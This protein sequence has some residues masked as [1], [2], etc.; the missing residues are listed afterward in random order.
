M[1][2]ATSQVGEDA[3]RIQKRRKYNSAASNKRYHQRQKLL[4]HYKNMFNNHPLITYLY[5]ARHLLIKHFDDNTVV[6]ILTRVGQ[7]Y[8]T[9]ERFAQYMRHQFYQ[10]QRSLYN[11][12][13]YTYSNHHALVIGGSPTPTIIHSDPSGAEDELSIPIESSKINHPDVVSSQPSVNVNDNNIDTMSLPPIIDEDQFEQGKMKEDQSDMLDIMRRSGMKSR[14][15]KR[16]AF[17]PGRERVVIAMVAIIVDLYSNA[18]NSDK[19]G[20]V[21][22]DAPFGENANTP[23]PNCNARKVMRNY[24][25]RVINLAGWMYCYGTATGA[26]TVGIPPK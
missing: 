25:G 23:T 12:L 7:Q 14:L 16:W 22:I 11:G 18:L 20:S 8:L 6:G 21:S 4:L 15:I 2:A 17:Q 19:G 10:Q 9:Q 13:P 5:K 26:Y 1:E 24:Y 3:A